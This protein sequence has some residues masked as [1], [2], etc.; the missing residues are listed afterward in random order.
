MKLPHTKI[1]TIA[2]VLLCLASFRASAQWQHLKY[3]PYL[4]G[5]N[6]KLK[7]PV[8]SYRYV[9]TLV[10]KDNR[11]ALDSI[12][13]VLI[14]SYGNYMDS[15]TNGISLVSDG[16]Y[17]K[18]QKNNKTAVVY[19]IAAIQKKLGMKSEDMGN[20]L[21]TIPDSLLNQFSDLRVQ[22]LP[23]VLVLTYTMKRE[24]GI[25]EEIE[26]SINRKDMSLLGLK[27]SFD[28]LDR[29]GSSTGYS[30]IYYLYNFSNRIEPG[31]IELERFLS[32]KEGKV[33]LKGSFGSYSLNTLL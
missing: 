12:G 7:S 29:W 31:A 15:N 1:R 30:K 19:N 28:E 22:E 2:W 17:M 4:Q 24:A 23:S 8:L 5:A 32:I 6:L 33:K 27:L 18:A 13:G 21:V 14:K 20:D 10:D 9:V 11:S 3:L 25:L 16:Y 26:F